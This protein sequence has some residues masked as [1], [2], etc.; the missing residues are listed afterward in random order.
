MKKEHSLFD[1]CIS[2]GWFCGIASSMSQLGLRSV[3][4]PFDW[5]YS[6]YWAVL[7]QMILKKS[8]QNGINFERGQIS[9]I[10]EKVIS[11][12]ARG[13]SGRGW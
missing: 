13:C 4:G 11:F 9:G 10:E 1:N 12:Y 8:Y 5:C 6:D 3:S 2:L 7:T